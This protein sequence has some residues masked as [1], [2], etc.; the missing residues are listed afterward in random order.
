MVQNPKNSAN[1]ED[2]S[3]YG[4]NNAVPMPSKLKMINSLCC[5]LDVLSNGGMN[6]NDQQ[7][8]TICRQYGTEEY[9]SE[10]TDFSSLK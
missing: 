9:I 2:E 10:K 3:D 7:S 6:K 8:Q 5:Y 4:F 1:F